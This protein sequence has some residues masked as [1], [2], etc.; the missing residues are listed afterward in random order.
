[1]S[2]MIKKCH[3]G[4]THDDALQLVEYL[5]LKGGSVEKTNEGI[6]LDLKMLRSH[7]GG[8]FQVDMAR[9]AQARLHVQDSTTPDGKPCCGYRLHYRALAR[10]ALFSL[11]DPT[12]D[13]GSHANAAIESVRGWVAREK[14]HKTENQRQ[15]E[16]FERLGEHCLARGDKGGYRICQRCSLELEN[17]GT[18]SA[19][20]M[21]EAAVWLDALRASP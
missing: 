10:G 1:M 2:G 20:T 6:A 14:Q 9:F 7:G 18:I 16:T 21:A 11:I 8:H 3:K 17:E 12:G 15:I 13:L 19:S 5:M 4:R